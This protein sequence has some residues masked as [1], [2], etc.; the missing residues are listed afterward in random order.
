MLPPDLLLD[1]TRRY[2]EGH[3]R[4]HALPHIAELLWLGRDLQLTDEQVL[5][6][7]YHDVVYAVPSQTNELDSAAH[8]K[9]QLTAAGWAPDRVAIVEQIVLDTRLH[10]PSIPESAPVL[11]LDL[12]P[13]AA[14]WDRFVQ[15]T[16]AIRFEYGSVDD[17]SFAAGQGAV[18]EKFLQRE[19][20]YCTEWGA[21]FEAA[22]R[23]NLRRGLQRLQR[24]G[25]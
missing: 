20:I 9:A 13:L 18:F 11:D 19:R 12:S 10:V 5:A 17:A 24:G 14:P 8:A 21:Q 22:A 23:A 25:Q 6:I 15:N 2:C 3:R 4:Y 7:W 16:D 1:L